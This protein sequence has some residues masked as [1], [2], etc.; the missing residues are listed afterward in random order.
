MIIS[1]AEPQAV[2]IVEGW[3]GFWLMRNMGIVP[4]VSCFLSISEEVAK[5]RMLSRNTYIDQNRLIFE[6]ENIYFPGLRRYDEY[7]KSVGGCELSVCCDDFDNL[8]IEEG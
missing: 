4:G 7:L 5:K 8:Q 6:M 3:R 1:G 2:V